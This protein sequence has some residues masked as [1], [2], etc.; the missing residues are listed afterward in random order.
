MKRSARGVVLLGVLCGVILVD[1]DVF[2]DL[3]VF[4]GVLFFILGVLHG[5][6]NDMLPLHGDNGTLEMLVFLFFFQR[7]VG[8]LVREASKLPKDSSMA[9][10]NCT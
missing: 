10:P 1:L 7:G 9:D 4:N 8:A 6:E 5:V 2:L 3:S